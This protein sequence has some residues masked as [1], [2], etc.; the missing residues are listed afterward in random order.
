MVSLSCFGTTA[1]LQAEPAIII[2]VFIEDYWRNYV[3]P[4]KR[5]VNNNLRK[6]IKWQMD[7]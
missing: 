4:D 1:S 2:R 6:K 5:F 7:H 3:V